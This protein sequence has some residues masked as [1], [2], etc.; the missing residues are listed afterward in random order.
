MKT[1]NICDIQQK[2]AEENEILFSFGG[3]LDFTITQKEKGLFSASSSEKVLDNVIQKINKYCSQ[4]KKTLTDILINATEAFGD[5]EP[6]EEIGEE[7]DSPLEK[8]EIKIDPEIEKMRKIREKFGIDKD[9]NISKQAAARLMLD[10]IQLVETDTSKSGFS[11]AP[12]EDNLFVWHVKMFGFHDEKQFTEDLKKYKNEHGSGKDYVLFEM[13]FPKEY[14]NKPPF[15]R[16]LT[17]RFVHLTGHVTIGGSICMQLLTNSGWSP[18][19]S[20]ESIFIQIHCEMLTGKPRIDF[21]NTSPYS[22]SEADEA[23]VRVAERY[24]WN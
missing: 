3:D 21:N 10:Y 16:V 20:I 15:I 12:F 8:V 1:K 18:S 14:P 7:P 6:E 22:R 23:F 9:K 13:T 11:A 17:P 24:K 4:G 2:K 5:F 19:N